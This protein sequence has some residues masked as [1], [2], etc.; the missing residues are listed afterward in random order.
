M[1]VGYSCCYLC[2]HDCRDL[3]KET[4]KTVS[5]ESMP[6]RCLPRFTENVLADWA[7]KSFVQPVDEFYFRSGLVIGCDNLSV[8]AHYRNVLTQIL[9]DFAILALDTEEVT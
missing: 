4:F 6:T 9:Y 5:T 2:P 7:F 3:P 1:V 8:F